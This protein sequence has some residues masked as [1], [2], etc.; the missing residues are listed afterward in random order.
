[1]NVSGYI[2]CK[3]GQDPPDCEAM[4]DGWWSGIEVTELVHRPTL[5]RSFRA[6]KDR[7]SGKDPSNAEAYFEWH[8]DNFVTELRGLISRA[9][10]RARSAMRRNM[11]FQGLKT[12]WLGHAQ[13]LTD[14]ALAI[15]GE[16]DKFDT[17]KGNRHPK[18][19]SLALLSRSLG[20]LK[21]IC[22]LLA[23]VGISQ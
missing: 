13:N 16:C 23:I 11:T 21:A 15:I 6:Q 10:Q 12:S 22:C 20:H 7:A 3:K 9:R 18:M 17:R 19:I 2:S 1:M 5:E 4:V 14:V 8:R